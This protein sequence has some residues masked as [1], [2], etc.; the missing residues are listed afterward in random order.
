MRRTQKTQAE[1]FVLVLSEAHDEMKRLL[2]LREYDAVLELLEQCQQGAI[3]LGELIE[4]TEGEGFVTIPLLEHYCELVYQIH[5]EIAQKQ[6]RNAEEWYKILREAWDAVGNSI[7][8][9]IKVQKEIVFMPYKASMWDSLESVW[10]A[11]AADESCRAYV[12]PIPYFD[13][14]QDGSFGQLHYEGYKLPENVPVTFYKDYDLEKRRPDAIYIHNPY[15]DCNFV[16]SVHPDY[17]SVKLKEYTDK[18]V[19]I[20]YFV[21]DEPESRDAAALEGLA[22]FVQTPGVLYADEVIV[23]SENMRLCYIEVLVQTMGESTRSYW[24]NKIKGNGSPKLEKVA[25]I[26]KEKIELPQEWKDKIYRADGSAK[27]VIL[28]NTGVSAILRE[29][30][31]MIEKIADT[32]EVFKQEREHVTLLWRPH[33][34]LR[35]TL[36]SMRP[37]LLEAYNRIVERYVTDSFGIYDDSADLDRAIAIADAYY[38]DQSSVVQLCKSIGMPVMIQNVNVRQMDGAQTE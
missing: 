34:L 3:K 15:D 7:Q 12:V 35:A 14:K 13:R 31:K 36:G 20:P 5:E 8:K 25:G 16:T 18:L 10:K 29:S 32:L 21:L 22:H 27:K 37:W 33:P 26:K 28:Y 30:E 2:E 38:G 9:D 11:A 24:E 17:Y 6:L 4:V 1:D 19:Y 23:Q